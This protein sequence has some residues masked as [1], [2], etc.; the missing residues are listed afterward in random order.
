MNVTSL[1]YDNR[2]V[3]LFYHPYNC[4]SIN[5]VRT[6]ERTVEIA[7]ALDFLSRCNDE[8]IEIGAVTPYYIPGIIKYVVDPTDKH[9]LVSHHTSLFDFDIKGKNILSISTIEHI[10]KNDYGGVSAH[11]NAIKALNMIL[12]KSLRCLIT[13]PFG[14]NRDLDEYVMHS[15][16]GKSINIVAFSRGQTCNDWKAETRIHQLKNISYGPQWANAVVVIEKFS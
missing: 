14:Y 13:F 4:G 5:D 1:T 7:I 9:A 10:G 11:E 3:P 6:T 15:P 12:R 16:F 2:I 8:I